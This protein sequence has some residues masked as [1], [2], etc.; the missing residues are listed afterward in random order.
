[1]EKLSAKHPRIR[2]APSFKD[3]TRKDL[4]LR[5]PA[6]PAGIQQSEG[7]SIFWAAGS[8]K[9]SYVLQIRLPTSSN[10]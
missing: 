2:M 5:T 1:M 4:K 7:I 8:K 3:L 9:L 6:T 10:L